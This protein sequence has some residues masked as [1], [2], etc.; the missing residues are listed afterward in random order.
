MRTVS[1]D[2]APRPVAAYSQGIVTGGLLFT[3]GMVGVDPSTRAMADGFEAQA[4]QS[5]ANVRAVLAAA[6][7]GVADLVKVTVYVVDVR[8]FAAFNALYERFLEGSRPVRSTVGVA[9]L[10][11]GALIE[12]DAIAALKTS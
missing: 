4:R 7:L 8:D 9:A 11:G 3:A 6:G 5:L 12:I 1:T 10:P 2:A